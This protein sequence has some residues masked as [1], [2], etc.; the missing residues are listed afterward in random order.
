[1]LLDGAGGD[2]SWLVCSVRGCRK[3][4]GDRS[5]P[6]CYDRVWMVQV[7]MRV[8]WFVESVVGGSRWGI[9]VDWLVLRV[10]G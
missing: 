8:D 2:E 7:G 5:R 1:M 6:A 3:Q 9:G 4:A 10:D